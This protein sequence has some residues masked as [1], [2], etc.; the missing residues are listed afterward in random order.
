M[1][2]EVVAGTYDCTLRGLSI[3]ILAPDEHVSAEHNGPFQ[4]LLQYRC[5]GM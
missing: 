5:V 1:E 4:N 2:L 3:D